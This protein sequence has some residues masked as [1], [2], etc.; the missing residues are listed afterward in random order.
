MQLTTGKK[1]HWVPSALFMYFPAERIE[2]WLSEA[3]FVDVH[4]TPNLESREMVEGW[5][6]GRGVENYT[7]SAMVEA[8]K[9]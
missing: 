2:A 7:A 9:P 4:V 6:S 3:G 5:A 8:R 1:I